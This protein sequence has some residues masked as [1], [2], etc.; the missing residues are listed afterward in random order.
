MKLRL[1][2][3]AVPLVMAL[4]ATVA[5]ANPDE[6]ALNFVNADI[7]ATVKA[8]G[9]ITGRNFV[10]DP[11]VKGTINIASA[12][13]VKRAEVYPILLSAL[14]QQGFTIVEGQGVSTV[15]PEA[16]AK[17][18]T[19]PVK[20]GR[21]KVSGNQLITKVY[22]LKYES[23]V[24]MVP[25]L[26]PLITANN[27]VAAYP[28]GNALVITD[29]A[30]NVERLTRIIESIDRPA[31]GEVL[32]IRLQHA[33]AFD[34]SQTIAQLMPEI[35]VQGGAGGARP[36]D[37]AQRRT[38]VV[39]DVR[40]NALLVRSESPAQMQ[41]I[42]ELVATLDQ[43]GASAGNIHVVYLKNAEAVKLAGTLKG[44]LTGS[45]SQPV[46]AG[47]TPAPAPTAMASAGLSGA[48]PATSS[49]PTPAASPTVVDIDGARV[50]I[51]ADA[52]TNSLII[53]A[54]DH[55]YNNLRSVIDKL[56]VRRAQV[57][58][59]AM[60]AEVN[61]SK[62]GEF[63]FQWLLAGGS[64]IAAAGISALAPTGAAN[65]IASIANAILSDQPYVPGGFNVGILNGNPAKGDTPSLGVLA[66]ALQRSGNANILS[67]PNLITLD[68]EEAK[69]M[70]GQNIPI[71][72]GTQSSTGSNPNPF[73]TVE[74]QDIGVTLSVKPQVSEGGTITMT[75]YQEVSNV[76]DSV[77]TDGTGIAT[78]KRSLQ[79]KVLIDDGQ[80]LV[81]G[82]LIEDKVGNG[83]SKVPG[84][85]D[86]PL[87]GQLFRYE[88]RDWKKTN[89]MIFLRPFILRDGKAADALSNARYQYLKAQQ[90][91]FALP[92][93]LMLPTV[94]K[95]ELPASLP[96]ADAAPISAGTPK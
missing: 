71:I 47:N 4:C 77:N 96:Q 2:L 90:Q 94:P 80:V 69:I 78:S 67:T 44:I 19:G 66:T 65:N 64:N 9:L 25:I 34:V 55:V 95:I 29:Y 18:Y 53:T 70:V 38:T 41:Q 16:D 12:Q 6:V 59:E 48:A 40:S 62:V 39:A 61:V 7:E 93:H 33:S 26:R 21:D 13:P 54:P 20:R 76:D 22:P 87:L 58:V 10:I 15:L 27:T 75:V 84:L 14:R 56:D 5:H 68:N 46:S 57:F 81:L 63:G 88:T 91:E 23:A 42:R 30:D 82:G 74:R 49:A 32:P 85:G 36:A 43:P 35:S 60:I 28:N 24:Q 1:S 83:Q 72:T 3:C 37:Q 89:L 79:S 17:T 8:V 50:L 11:R 31:S 51:Q 86:I 92:D 52:M 73:T 45:D